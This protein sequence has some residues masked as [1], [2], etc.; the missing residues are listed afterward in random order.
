MNDKEGREPHTRLQLLLLAANGAQK[1]G[2]EGILC[3]GNKNG[4]KKQEEQRRELFQEEE[5]VRLKEQKT[6]K[7]KSSTHK[8]TS[9]SAA[10]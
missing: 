8:G 9:W 3:E 10:I 2:R 7:S 1:S 5:G 6:C 4:E